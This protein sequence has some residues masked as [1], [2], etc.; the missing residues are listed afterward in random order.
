MQI[1]PG[2]DQLL[3]SKKLGPSCPA[4]T[5][6][7][8]PRRKKKKKAWGFSW[9]KQPGLLPYLCQNPDKNKEKEIER[10]RASLPRGRLLASYVDETQSFHA[11]VSKACSDE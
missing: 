4:S 11:N 7:K 6:E 8:R 1:C 9:R 5:R 2:T 3:R 10:S